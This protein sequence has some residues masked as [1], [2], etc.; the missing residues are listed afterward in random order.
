MLCIADRAAG[1]LAVARLRAQSYAIDE[2][3]SDPGGL[4]YRW[5]LKALIPL[6]FALLALQSLARR[7]CGVAREL[8]EPRRRAMS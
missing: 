1:H 3:S 2:I 8:R 6:G 5:V 7:C 4:P